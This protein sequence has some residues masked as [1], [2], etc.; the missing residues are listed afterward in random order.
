MVHVLSELSFQMKEFHEVLS[1]LS[2]KMRESL[3]VL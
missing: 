2:F 3:V 1:V